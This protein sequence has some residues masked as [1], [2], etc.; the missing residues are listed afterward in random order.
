[1]TKGKINLMIFACFLLLIL[2]SQLILI[3]ANIEATK[4]NLISAEWKKL[5]LSDAD[6]GYSFG[7]HQVTD[8]DDTILMWVKGK[9]IGGK[10]V[11]FKIYKIDGLYN[12]IEK[13]LEITTTSPFPD[14][15]SPW[16][17]SETGPEI[18]PEAYESGDFVWFTWRPEPG[19]YYYTAELLETGETIRSENIFT[20][21][22]SN[23]A[24]PKAD[25]Y[26]PKENN[27]EYITGE[28]ITFGQLSKDEDDLLKW[29]WDF[30]DN[31]KSIEYPYDYWLTNHI[32]WE[33]GEYKVKLCVQETEPKRIQSDCDSIII[34]IIEEEPIEPKPL[35][36]I[37]S[38]P[39]ENTNYNTYEI[40]IIAKATRGTETATNVIFGYEI[41]E[42]GW[43]EFQSGDLIKE[44]YLN[45]GKNTLDVFVRDKTTNE[46]DTIKDIIFYIDTTTEDTTPPEIT[47]ISPEE[48][49]YK[50][51]DI[52]MH[53]KLNEEG[54][55]QYS[56]TFCQFTSTGGGCGK[57]PLIEMETTDNINFYDFLEDRSDGEYTIEFICEDLAGNENKESV[58]FSIDTTITDDEP[59]I[60]NVISPEEG[61]K[62]NKEDE[63]ELKVISNE[64][65]YCWYSIDSEDADQEMEKTSTLSG[66]EFISSINLEEGEHYVYFYCEDLAENSAEQKV[67]FEILEE[68]GDDDDDDDEEDNEGASSTSSFIQDCYD[69]HVCNEWKCEAGQLIR[70]CFYNSCQGTAIKET[71]GVCGLT[72]EKSE[73][74]TISN[75][76]SIKQS[77]IKNW[78]L[79]LTGLLISG[80]L[81]LLVLIILVL[82][83]KKR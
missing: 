70:L 78:P 35:T 30:G 39:K 77:K 8:T 47:I 11:K 76:D 13:E 82:I 45:E 64:D 7:T 4:S 71:K 14:H 3:S 81:L 31:T 18:W 53:V 19:G 29:T 41:N 80:I 67:N 22:P 15:G 60:I 55:C 44:Q 37:V 51:N 59:P 65:G 72:T 63:L 48:K 10:E 20:I 17:N 32:Y 6:Y 27:R 42:Y 24:K 83:A 61:E 54:Y 46:L 43:I 12:V 62:Y 9:N 36:L 25:I 66:Y 56:L 21:N 50:V 58:S 5:D 33:P 40:P 69:M 73:S 49:T 52:Q 2:G 26:L 1:M 38:N 74:L 23:N 57:T 16:W 68:N 75:K 34:K 79:S 28:I